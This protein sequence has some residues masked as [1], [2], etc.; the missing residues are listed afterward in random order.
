MI[1]PVICLSVC[2]CVCVCVHECGPGVNKRPQDVFSPPRRTI[3]SICL[4]AQYVTSEPLYH[5]KGWVKH[6]PCSLYWSDLENA[7]W[8]T[9]L[10]AV[11]HSA[12]DAG[13]ARKNRWI[14]ILCK[15]YG[16]SQENPSSLLDGFHS[17]PHSQ[18][19]MSM[20][21]TPYTCVYTKESYLTVWLNWLHL[22]AGNCL[23]SDGLRR[24]II[25]IQ[26]FPICVI[27]EKITG[28]WVGICICRH[29]YG[30]KGNLQ[31]LVFPAMFWGR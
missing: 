17:I 18:R 25:I 23:R 8:D 13:I 21:F 20:R 22:F 16:C 29:L 3:E 14:F 27:N 26:D 24:W 10:S 28:W 5:R 4:H 1:L 2:V 9:E 19:R 7:L 31:M 15:S 12:S 6:S 11:Y 30:W